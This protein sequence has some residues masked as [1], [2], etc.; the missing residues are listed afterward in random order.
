[1][2]I[3]WNSAL[4]LIHI[5]FICLHGIT[6]LALLHVRNL[7]GRSWKHGL[8]QLQS[9]PFCS[10]ELQSSPANTVL[11]FPLLPP[12]IQSCN[13]YKIYYS[14][15]TGV[16]Y[17][18]FIVGTRAATKLDF[19]GNPVLLVLGDR[20]LHS[21]CFSQPSPFIQ[22]A[23]AVFPQ[24]LSGLQNSI[25]DHALLPITSLQIPLPFLQGSQLNANN[26]LHGKIVLHYSW[27]LCQVSRFVC[28]CLH[29]LPVP[30]QR[31]FS[32]FLDREIQRWLSAL[33]AVGFWLGEGDSSL[34]QQNWN[35]LRGTGALMVK[36]SPASLTVL[37]RSKSLVTFGASF[38]AWNAAIASWKCQI[39]ET[40]STALPEIKE[41]KNGD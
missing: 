37:R 33:I 18:P 1:M 35:C 3:S 15:V 28:G 30:T 14:S 5:S 36:K 20:L 29:I 2:W 41:C 24:L 38:A 12:R 11:N 40:A 39:R 27:M 22:A 10:Q 21:A 32:L 9:H 25:P 13:T 7:S 6:W 17:V 8:L 34:L 16:I 23:S 26:E 19:C 31:P 4:N